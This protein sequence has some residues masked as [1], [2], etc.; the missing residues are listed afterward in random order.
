[1]LAGLQRLQHQGT[2]GPALGEDRH[3]VDVWAGEHVLERGERA[4][5]VELVDELLRPFR[6]DIGGVQ[7]RDA[8]VLVEQDGEVAGELAGSDHAEGERHAGSFRRLL[9]C[10]S[11]FALGVYSC[12][13]PVSRGT[14]DAR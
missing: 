14:L 11:M 8:R 3:G 12:Q 4:G 10:G 5:E 2:V 1:V 6:D 9:R 7:G 13:P